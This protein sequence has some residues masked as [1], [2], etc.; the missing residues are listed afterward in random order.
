MAYSEARTGG[1]EQEMASR[2][3]A[4]R[5]REQ[6]PMVPSKLAYRLTVDSF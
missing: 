4:A 1:R 6:R 5:L 2:S 3:R